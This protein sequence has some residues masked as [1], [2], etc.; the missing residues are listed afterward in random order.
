M[1]VQNELHWE[2][3]EK[4]LGSRIL[5]KQELEFFISYLRPLKIFLSSLLHIW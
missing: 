1:N 4:V 3:S 2:R 5:Y